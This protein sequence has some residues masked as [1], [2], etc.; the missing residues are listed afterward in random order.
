LKQALSPNITT[1]SNDLRQASI[2]NTHT[3]GLSAFASKR[4]LDQA[5]TKMCVSVKEGRQPE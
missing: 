4:E 3:I 5:A 1:A 2:A